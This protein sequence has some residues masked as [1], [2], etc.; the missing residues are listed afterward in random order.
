MDQTR[1]SQLMPDGKP[2]TVR[3]YIEP[4]TGNPMA[5][6]PDEIHS[7]NGYRPDNRTCY[8]RI[9]QHSACHPSYLKKCRKA[10]PE[11]YAGLLEELVSIGYTDLV[12]K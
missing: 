1:K 7:F 8:S 2:V 4:V 6:F 11:Q 10:T 9:G 12:V 5:Y 3:F